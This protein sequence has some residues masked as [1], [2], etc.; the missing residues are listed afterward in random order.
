ACAKRCHASIQH[1]L[2]PAQLVTTRYPRACG[3]GITDGN[4]DGHHEFAIADHHDEQDAIN[5][6]E[7]PGVLAVPPAAHKA[8]LPTRLFEH[9]V[10]AHPGP[11]PAAACGLTR[12]GG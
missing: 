9:Q 8:Q 4:V 10:I 6:G 2:H 7:H 1:A 5:T 11:L 3:V 12:A